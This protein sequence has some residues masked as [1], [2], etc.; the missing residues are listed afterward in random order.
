LAK[1]LEERNDFQ[2]ARQEWESCLAYSAGSDVEPE[3]RVEALEKLRRIGNEKRGSVQKSG[4]T[5]EIES[6]NTRL[7]TAVDLLRYALRANVRR[8]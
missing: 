2:N 8:N 3:W 6:T 4:A 1:V 5:K 7:A